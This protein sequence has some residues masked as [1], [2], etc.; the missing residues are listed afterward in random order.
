MPSNYF[1][2]CLS[3]LLLPAI[4]PASGYFPL[5]QLFTSGDQSIE[6]SASVLPMNI[7]SWF[8]WG[9]TGSL[10]SKGLSSAFS[11]TTIRKH[12]SFSTQLSLGSNFHIYTWLLEKTIHLTLLAKW[13]SRFFKPGFS[14]TWTENS[15]MFKLDLEKAEE[16]EVKLQ[17][18]LGHRK[19]KRVPEKYL[20]LLY[21]LCQ[22]LWLCGSQQTVEN[23]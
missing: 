15:Q 12:Q 4:F 11:S 1:I 22:S 9:L 19:S 7:H 18:L 10:Q 17:H 6:A 5:S 14:S 21:W 23:S 2:L 16:S 3:L 8:L 13:F 20:L